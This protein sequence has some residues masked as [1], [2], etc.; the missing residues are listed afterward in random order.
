M[1]AATALAGFPHAHGFGS[2]ELELLAQGPK[3]ITPAAADHPFFVDA[4][5]AAAENAPNPRNKR[6][7]LEKTLADSPSDDAARLA[8]FRAAASTGADQ[9]A[10][11]S[12]EQFLER[13]MFGQAAVNDSSDRENSAD[14]GNDSAAISQ[15]Q[16]S[17]TLALEPA[18]VT[19]FTHE[20][21]LAMIRV[22]RLEEAVG[23]LQID[24]KLETSPEKRKLVASEIL[25]LEA[26]LRLE[27]TNAA[28][29]PILHA[30]L[31]QD[32]LV[33]PRLVPRATAPKAA[34]AAEAGKP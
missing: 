26:R 1:L 19:E 32:Q 22:G 12:I 25:D 11:A 15:V 6:E 16:T 5:L 14:A 20:I 23:Y 28:R 18:E 31:E 10:L 24:R 2:A 30:D 33:R 13:R 27:R 4:R 17:S 7:I 8:F 3:S 29:E 9:L 34:A 21:A